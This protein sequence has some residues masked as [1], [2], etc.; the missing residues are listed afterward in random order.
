LEDYEND[1][2]DKA[3]GFEH[4]IMEILNKNHK[5]LSV[6]DMKLMIEG[7]EI[8][9]GFS[10]MYPEKFLLFWLNSRG[11]KYEIKSEYD[12]DTEKN[13]FLIVKM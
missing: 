10:G 11:I 6:A 3:T 9:S 13:K 4:D 12:F 2:F 1:A 5:D 8:A 7:F